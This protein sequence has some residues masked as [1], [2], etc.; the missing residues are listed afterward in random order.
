[1]PR[2]FFRYKANRKNGL[3]ILD[4]ILSIIVFAFGEIYAMV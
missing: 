1:M 2:L 4:S 3:P